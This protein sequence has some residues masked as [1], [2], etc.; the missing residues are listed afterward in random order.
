MR[1]EAGLGGPSQDRRKYGTPGVRRLFG[2]GV[3]LCLGTEGLTL[4]QM[5][6]MAEGFDAVEAAMDDPGPYRSLIH[7]DL[8]N[9][10]QTVD[11]GDTLFLVDFEQAKVGHALLDFAKPMIGK[12]E[13]DETRRVWGRQCPGFPLELPTRYRELPE[14]TITLPDRYWHLGA[15]LIHGATQLIGRMAAWD[16]ARP[17]MAVDRSAR[18]AA[19]PFTTSRSTCGVSG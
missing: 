8:L 5:G 3:A 2:A 13:V 4:R 12:F 1:V 9:A 15:V 17:E 10:S 18:P 7:D 6:A 14:A 16:P 11:I 19:T